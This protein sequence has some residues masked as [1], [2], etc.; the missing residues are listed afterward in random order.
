MEIE[1]HQRLFPDHLPGLLPVSETEL[2]DL[3]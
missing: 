1:E 2:A 3:S